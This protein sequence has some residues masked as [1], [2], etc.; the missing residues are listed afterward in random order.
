M[1]L[2]ANVLRENG[3]YAGAIDLYNQI[4]LQASAAGVRDNV[5]QAFL[6]RELGAMI[7]SVISPYSMGLTLPVTLPASICRTV[8]PVGAAGAGAVSAGAGAR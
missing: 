4:G 6:L 5:F 8:G 2:K 7:S 1:L 3:D